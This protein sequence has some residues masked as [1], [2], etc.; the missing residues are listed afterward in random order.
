[1]LEIEDADDG[2][3]AAQ[4]P[5][6]AG[7]RAGYCC[8]DHLFAAMLILEQTAEWNQELWVVAIDFEKAFDTVEHKSIWA[9]LQSQWMPTPYIN[10]LSNMYNNQRGRFLL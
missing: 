3:P 4:C 10:L 8:D 5:D 6:Q 2:M 1:M 9:A 7:F